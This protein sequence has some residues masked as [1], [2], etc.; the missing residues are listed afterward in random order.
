MK[1]IRNS[2]LFA[3]AVIAAACGK[4]EALTVPSNEGTPVHFNMTVNG[5]GTKTVTDANGADR[6]VSWREGDAAGIFVNDEAALH[7]YS[8]TAAEG[9]T[10][11]D[12]V[13]AEADRNY[14]FYAWYPYDSEIVRPA[15]A[16]SLE[17]SVLANQNNQYEDNSGF[18]LSDVLVANKENV[19]GAALENVELQYSHAFAMVE[20]LVSGTEV[21][22][23]PKSVTLNNIVRTATI[24]LKTKAVVL[25]DGEAAGNVVM[26]K[27]E[28]VAA[29]AKGY[30]YRAIVPAQSITA[31]EVLL[32]VALADKTY[33]F[34]AP[35]ASPVAYEANRYR[36]IEAI[37]GN[38]EGGLTVKFPAGSVDAWTPSEELP[39]GGGEEAV[40]DL[41][42]IKIAD[43]TV[44]TY[45]DD[46]TVAVP[47]TFKQVKDAPSY[48]V[49]PNHANFVNETSWA[50]SVHSS[51]TGKITA[52][53]MPED[54]CIRMHS[55][56][57]D[58]FNFNGWYKSGLRFHRVEAFVPG[59]YR[60]KFV[61][62]KG[63]DA[64]FD[65]FQLYART[66]VTTTHS[67]KAEP[68]WASTLFYMKTGAA[69]CGARKF[70]K[71]T[72]EWVETTV[73]FDFSK[74]FSDIYQTTAD[75]KGKPY[76]EEMYNDAEAYGMFNLAF[77]PN[78]NG[79]ADFYIKDVELV[80]VTEETFNT[81][82]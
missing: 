63:E 33:R 21:T 40:T 74:A 30:L 15:S 47:G 9:W 48:L 39:D 38:A 29:D 28:P 61:A 4:N 44:E 77:V 81:G 18:D 7:K 27:V 14:S 10:S 80:K 24:Y 37:V 32:E 16:S 67:D 79:I 66:C 62:K 72:D 57:A 35:A 68:K 78:G 41:V 20:V 43:L 65:Q 22:A 17:A 50:M 53:F 12:A 59:Y 76:D 46:G 42:S 60:L 64:T 54:N 8:F 51:E 58:A 1:I 45:N 2:A 73:Y 25:K 55:T 70:I 6:V 26:Y 71:C 56:T 3:A 5:I 69:S 82:K 49:D 31:G 19:T 36:R 23:A 13:F 34:K 52:E 75:D 11:T